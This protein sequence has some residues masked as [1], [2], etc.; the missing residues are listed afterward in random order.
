MEMNFIIRLSCLLG[1]NP[2]KN[3]LDPA[4]IPAAV[5]LIVYLKDGD[6]CI[7]L[8]KRSHLVENHKGEI[9][10]PGGRK[11]ENDRT[12]LDTALREL[13]EEMGIVAED[14]KILG[15]LDNVR[16]NSNYVV[17]VFVGTIGSSYNFRP[18][19]NEVAKVLEVPIKVLSDVHQDV[20]ECES[21]T[22]DSPIYTYE[23]HLIHGATAK[24]IARFLEIIAGT[25]RGIKNES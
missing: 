21:D 16:T 14:V 13:W 6:Y 24:I 20:F 2:K 25:E 1:I 17:S 18:N 19:S 22:F 15:E 23:E 11:D 5:F 3:I 12:L 4:L 7:L 10:F 9:S 8:N